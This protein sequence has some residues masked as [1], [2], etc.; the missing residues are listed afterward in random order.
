MERLYNLSKGYNKR[1]PAGVNPYQIMTRL[2]E[3]CGEV[4]SAIN[5]WENSGIKRQK[6]GAPSKEALADEVKQA[7][8]ALVQIAIYY[9]IETELDASIQASL[10]RMRDEGLIQ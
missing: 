8:A 6:H 10:Q 1:Y 3:E 5:L 7:M 4:A 9:Q 2:L